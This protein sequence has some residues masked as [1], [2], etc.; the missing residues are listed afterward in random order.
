[1]DAAPQIHAAQHAIH[2]KH[3]VVLHVAQRALTRDVQL[4]AVIGGIL[5]LGARGQRDPECRFQ[6]CCRLD[7]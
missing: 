7:Q 3:R 5:L 6:T 4:A 2:A 1:M